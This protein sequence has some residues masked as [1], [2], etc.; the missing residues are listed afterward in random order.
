MHPDRSSPQRGQPSPY[1][2][3]GQSSA[4]SPPAINIIT[5]APDPHS[6]ASPPTLPT[7]MDI[8]S[9]GVSQDQHSL[10]TPVLDAPPQPQH[11]EE[12][13]SGSDLDSLPHITI[14][15]FPESEEPGSP[16]SPPPGSPRPGEVTSLPGSPPPGEVNPIWSPEDS[17]SDEEDPYFD[18]LEDK[19][20]NTAADALSDDDIDYKAISQRQS[21]QYAEC[22]LEHYN[23]NEENKI[24]Y[25]LINAITFC[26][27]LVRMGC[28]SHVNFTA[29]AKQPNA[30][31]EHFFAELC[32]DHGTLVPTYVVSLEGIKQVGGLR[33][34]KFD[35]KFYPNG[36]PVDTQNCY[37]CNHNLKHPKNGGLYKMG[38]IAM[39]DYYFGWL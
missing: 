17:P 35:N 8:D 37:A 28:Y 26:D 2:R 13:E 20:M 3:F 24:K 11:Q 25:E 18:Y 1:V 36:L 32:R 38:H 12:L 23:N 19:F 39:S 10:L 14:I 21:V 33:G 16:T 5:D 22:A 34:S 15:P 31:V 9:T 30:K 29:K 4:P 6:C 7:F 27:T